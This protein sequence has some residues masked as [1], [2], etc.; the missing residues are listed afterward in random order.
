[1]S[2]AK[3]GVAKLGAELADD[4]EALGRIEELIDSH[5]LI[6]ILTT[7][8]IGRGM[9]QQEVAVRMGCNQSKVSRLEDGC[10][11]DLS[12]GDLQLYLN[13]IDM[14]FS[15]IFHDSRASLQERTKQLVFAIHENLEKLADIARSEDGNDQAVEKINQFCGEV[16]MNFIVRY[17]QSYQKIQQVRP[18]ALTDKAKTLASGHGTEAAKRECIET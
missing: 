12:F 15:M 6:R 10:D 11:D 13:A 16:L 5:Q 17:A 18:R 9:T 1:M 3:R 14:S 8:R 2:K 4:P 7:G